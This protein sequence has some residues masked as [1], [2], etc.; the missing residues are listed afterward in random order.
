MDLTLG[1][2]AY[3]SIDGTLKK[4]MRFGLYKYVMHSVLLI[5]G[6]GFGFGR[7]K[8]LNSAS[9]SFSAETILLLSA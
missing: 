8:A 6:F 1:Y 3:Y 7:N 2:T 5:F 9:V 4:P